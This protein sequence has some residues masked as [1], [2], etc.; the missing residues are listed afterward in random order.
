MRAILLILIIAVVAIIGLIASG[1]IDIRQT[2][3]GSIPTAE[4]D[5]GA[6]RA[7]AGESPAF[8]VET[9]TVAVGSKEKEV[10]VKVPSVEIRPPADANEAAATNGAR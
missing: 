6:I 7:T 10:K 3:G 1:L 4:L 8:R 5:N 9:G 2:R